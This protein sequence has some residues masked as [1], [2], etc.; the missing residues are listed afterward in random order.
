MKSEAPP[1]A[2][3]TQVPN[4]RFLLLVMAAI[5][6]TAIVD[7]L[8]ILPLGPQYMRVFGIS[9]GQFGLI[10]SAYAISAGVSG[11]AAGFLLDRYDRKRALLWLYLGF[12]VGTLLCA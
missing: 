3:T 12:T 9:P 7:F 1:S 4:E 5:Q 10:V 6:F 2:E 8:I 11:V